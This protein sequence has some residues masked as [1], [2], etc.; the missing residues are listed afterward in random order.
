MCVC[1]CV[2]LCVWEGGIWAVLSLWVSFPSNLAISAFRPVKCLH[3]VLWTIYYGGKL[4]LPF[5]K[6]AFIFRVKVEG[7]FNST[8]THKIFYT[9]MMLYLNLLVDFSYSLHCMGY[10]S[11]VISQMKNFLGLFVFSL[12]YRRCLNLPLTPCHGS[13]N[14]GRLSFF[15]LYTQ[16]VRFPIR[17]IPHSGLELQ[18][19]LFLLH[20]IKIQRFRSSKQLRNLYDWF[21]SRGEL[22]CGR[23]IGVDRDVQPKV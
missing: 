2:F 12:W 16:Y 23:S 5:V 15:F 18:W 1:V 22:R 19:M 6:K 17:F 4:T 11:V 7:S 14:V 9:L 21:R 10:F 13:N 20:F 8:H 3:Y